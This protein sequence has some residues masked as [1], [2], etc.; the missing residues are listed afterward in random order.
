MNVMDELNK[1]NDDKN[2]FLNYFCITLNIIAC[3][4][5][6]GKVRKYFSFKTIVVRV[7]NP[8]ILIDSYTS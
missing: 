3:Q 4:N 5:D 6:S 8:V 1:Q 7:F 2:K